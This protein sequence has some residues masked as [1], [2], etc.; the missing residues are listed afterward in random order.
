MS[1]NFTV[2]RDIEDFSCGLRIYRPSGEIVVAV[3]DKPISVL[4]N[5]SHVARFDFAATLPAGGYVASFVFLE[6]QSDA[7]SKIQNILGLHNLYVEFSVEPDDAYIEP[8]TTADGRLLNPVVVNISLDEHESAL[9]PILQKPA[10]AGS[11]AQALNLEEIESEYDRRYRATINS[12]VEKMYLKLVGVLPSKAEMAKSSEWIEAGDEGILKAL[13]EILADERSWNESIKN[14]AGRVF[15]AVYQGILERD[16][17]FKTENLKKNIDLP[18]YLK[19][20]VDSREYSALAVSKGRFKK[21]EKIGRL[22]SQVD[23]IKINGNA[24]FVHTPLGGAFLYCALAVCRQL[25][26]EFPDK[27]VYLVSDIEC[28]DEINASSFSALFIDGIYTTDQVLSAEID[29]AVNPGFIISPSEW[30]IEK[31]IQMAKLY[32]SALFGIWSDGFRN[33][34]NTMRWLPQLTVQKVYFF[35]FKANL[36]TIESVAENVIPLHFI[37]DAQKVLLKSRWGQ[38]PDVADKAYSVFYP[39]YWWRG[40]YKFKHEFIVASWLETI[41]EHSPAEELVVIKSSPLYTDEGRVVSDLRARLE[42]Q[43]R[44]VMYTEEFCEFVGADKK[45][46]ALPAE[47]LFFL[48]ILSQARMHYVLDGSLANIIA[49]HPCIKKP[50]SLVL[51][52]KMTLGKASG[53]AGVIHNL[54]G[55][56]EGL[57]KCSEFT[58]VNNSSVGLG[59]LPAVVVINR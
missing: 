57:M 59:Q 28:P 47:D 55:Q 42:S 9:K 38:L 4:M 44:N 56:M 8:A 37:W 12:L 16:P 51:A 34:A 26:A 20:V 40:A 54:A 11:V 49:S 39:R 45:L 52:S 6:G 29:A 23:A 2:S 30:L 58:L 50:V 3:V 22:A 19:S 17:E 1:V 24:V 25:K 35:G 46:A 10:A 41:I 48:G 7:E 53:F 36:A 18:K 21:F 43:G 5:G 13:E 32:P 27:R 31:P 33:V 14:N 15:A